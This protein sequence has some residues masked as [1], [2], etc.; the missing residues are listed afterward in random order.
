MEKISFGNKFF[1]TV[2]LPDI[3]T[4]EGFLLEAI[5]VSNAIEGAACSGGHK[6]NDAVFYITMNGVNVLLANLNNNEQGSAPALMS[7][8]IGSN[9]DDRYASIVIDKVLADQILSANPDGFQLNIVPHPDNTN[10][11]AD[12]TWVR[13]KDKNGNIIYS[14]CSA[15][16]ELIDLTSLIL[17]S[18]DQQDRLKCADEV[19]LRFS[20][21][22]LNIG[23]SYKVYYNVIDHQQFDTLPIN[24]VSSY[25]FS[26]HCCQNI[27]NVNQN[28][29]SFDFLAESVNMN[30]KMNLRL[31]CSQSA[32][33]QI[34]LIKNNT[35]LSKDIAQVV[36][37]TCR[38]IPVESITFSPPVPN[39]DFDI[40]FSNLE[41]IGEKQN[42]DFS[43]NSQIPN[44]IKISDTNNTNILNLRAFNLSPN[45][46]YEYSINFII[47]SEHI[48]VSPSSGN[49][50]SG[51]DEY[52]ISSI[53][54]LHSSNNISI[55]YAT[56]KDSQTNLVRNTEWVIIN[57][58]DNCTQLPLNVHLTEFPRNY[59]LSSGENPDDCDLSR[60]IC[61]LD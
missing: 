37:P 47:G 44:I 15:Q 28:E 39:V 20:I 58:I 26:D 57:N 43:N 23:D 17:E 16:G 60:Q 40:E 61:L 25:S 6:C 14:S 52:F 1:D 10:P 48:S 45:H 54:S 21:S 46:K 11:H 42:F 27:I 34:A 33:V 53:L 4:L 51:G 59:D 31:K 18:L 5:Y 30:C 22:N 19:E 38:I 13:L 50:Y 29:N 56:I 8:G 12:I 35:T 9:E 2:I 24:M 49:F 3:F 32:L 41:I 7:D 55:L 36:C